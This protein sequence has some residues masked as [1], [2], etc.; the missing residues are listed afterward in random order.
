MQNDQEPCKEHHKEPLQ[1]PNTYHGRAV[2]QRG[3]IAQVNHRCLACRALII[4]VGR[5]V[6]THTRA[7]GAFYRNGLDERVKVTCGQ[8]CISKPT[9]GWKWGCTHQ[10]RRNQDLAS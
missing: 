10:L 1:T 5:D 4:H 3:R 8:W 2:Q 9:G 6:G 7:R